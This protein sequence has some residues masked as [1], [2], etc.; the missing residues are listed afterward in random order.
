MTHKNY[1]FKKT[2]QLFF[3]QYNI[4]V[5][6]IEINP[7]FL[8]F[9]YTNNDEEEWSLKENNRRPLDGNDSKS[10]SL[11]F[12]LKRVHRIDFKRELKYFNQSDPL[13]PY[14]L[15]AA[16]IIAMM[17]ILIRFLS[18]YDYDHEQK[19]NRLQFLYDNS[20]LSCYLSI[21]ITLFALVFTLAKRSPVG[22]IFRL[23][24]WF[25]ITS[26]LVTSTMLD[27]AQ[28]HSF[29]QPQS[30]KSSETVQNFNITQEC[31]HRWVN[32]NTFFKLFL[33]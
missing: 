12:H 3:R 4:K 14:Y 9:I 21:I 24:I 22:V 27:M 29:I 7:I 16:L 32:P 8:F 18:L 30:S 17:I 10:H 5:S 33:F 11:W 26:L 2:N 6:S 15:I 19:I 28:C 31:F 1:S 20:N 13:F 23:I 25:I